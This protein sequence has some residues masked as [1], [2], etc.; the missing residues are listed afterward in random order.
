MEHWTAELLE[1]DNSASLNFKPK[2]ICF[3]LLDSTVNRWHGTITSPPLGIGRSE[4]L[5]AGCWGPTPWSPASL[6]SWCPFHLRDKEELCALFSAHWKF[7]FMCPAHLQL[8]CQGFLPGTWNR[9]GSHPG[10]PAGSSGQGRTPESKRNSPAQKIIE[11]YYSYLPYK[12]AFLTTA[13]F[14]ILPFLK[15]WNQKEATKKCSGIINTPLYP[16]SWQGHLFHWE[17]WRYIS[18]CGE[19]V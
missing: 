1:S 19:R 15:M 10:L 14:T 12:C 11:K 6:G 5:L 8:T 3:D 18:H 4:G 7:F 17:G 16:G 2:N 13:H 9:P